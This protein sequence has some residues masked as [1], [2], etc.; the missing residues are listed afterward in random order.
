MVKR[1]IGRAQFLIVF[2]TAHRQVVVCWHSSL[3]ALSC[4]VCPRRCALQLLAPAI[5]SAMTHQ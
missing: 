2:F 4:M 3:L 1:T 5:D